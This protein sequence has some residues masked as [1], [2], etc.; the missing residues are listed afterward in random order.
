MPSAVRAC[1]PSSGPNPGRD[2]NPHAMTYWLAGGGVKGG[3]CYG[4]TDDVGYRA[5]VDRADVHD[6]HATLLH[7]I[8]LDHERLTYFHNGRRYRLTD[9][10]GKVIRPLLA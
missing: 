1:R 8:G 10:H 6:L 5:A 9:V 3:V 2:H 7:L 4:A